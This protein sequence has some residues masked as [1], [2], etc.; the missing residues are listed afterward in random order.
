MK[1]SPSLM[2][3]NAAMFSLLARAK[4]SLGPKTFSEKTN[5]YRHVKTHTGEKPYKC[6][7]CGKLFS[8]K[9]GLNTH[10]RIHTGERPFKCQECGKQFNQKGSLKT[11]K[12]RI[13]NGKISI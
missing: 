13:H 8:Q 12:M 7:E 5:L 10:M 1:P 4:P 6:Q 3:N 11:H 2:R 9:G